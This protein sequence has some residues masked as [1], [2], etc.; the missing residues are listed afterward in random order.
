MRHYHCWLLAFL[1]GYTYGIGA[2][3]AAKHPLLTPPQHSGRPNYI[4]K[5]CEE[6]DFKRTNSISARFYVEKLSD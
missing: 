4:Y 5:P 3:E 1:D 2:S 6:V